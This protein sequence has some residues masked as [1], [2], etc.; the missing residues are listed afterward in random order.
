MNTTELKQIIQKTLGTIIIRRDTTFT[1][2]DVE[3]IINNIPK[4][5]GD[6][7]VLSVHRL[8]LAKLGYDQ[9]SISDEEM[10][11]IADK[12]AED[13]LDNQYWVSLENIADNLKLK[14]L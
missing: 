7:P 10:E 8:D 1:F 9:Y 13:I 3:E 5:T 14:K 12:L 4:I 11:N 2:E 6:F